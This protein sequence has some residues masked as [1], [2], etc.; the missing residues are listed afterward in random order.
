LPHGSR[1]NRGT[2]PRLVQYINMFP[3]TFEEQEEW[4]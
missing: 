1:P 4:I 2:R 3:T